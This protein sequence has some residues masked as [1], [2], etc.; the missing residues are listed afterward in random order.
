MKSLVFQCKKGEGAEA[1]SQGKMGHLMCIV[2]FIVKGCDHHSGTG[3]A[4]QTGPGKIMPGEN[5]LEKAEGP[6]SE[7]AFKK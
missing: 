7:T 5:A 3:T 1:S 6:L 4:R 2:G